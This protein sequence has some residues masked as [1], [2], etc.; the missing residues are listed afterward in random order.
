[1]GLISFIKDRDMFGHPIGLTLKGDDTYNTLI[2][3][4]FSIV[5][6]IMILIYMVLNLRIMFT[7]GAG[8]FLGTIIEN[9]NVDDQGKVNFEDMH[10]V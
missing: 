7:P 8:D 9:I 1:M 6:N 10:L 3:G 4:F 2:G 5:I